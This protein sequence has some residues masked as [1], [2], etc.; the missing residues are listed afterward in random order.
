MDKP[1]QL[2]E[3]DLIKIKEVCQEFIDF[4]DSDEYHADKMNY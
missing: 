2:P 4:L 1:K 3:P